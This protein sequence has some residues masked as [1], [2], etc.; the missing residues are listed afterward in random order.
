M[1]KATKERYVY[2]IFQSI[3]KG[4]DRGNRRIS[5]G[6]QKT[7]KK[8]LLDRLTA[9]TPRGGNVLDVCCGTGDISLML[10]DARRDLQVTGLDFSPAMLERAQWRNKRKKKRE[11]LYFQEGNALHL[12]YE[13]DS[14][15]AVCISFGLRNTT[16]YRKVLLEMKRVT[17][18]GGYLYCLDS[19]VPDRALVRPFYTL[20]FHHIMPVIG[21]GIRHR[22]E[23]LWLYRSTVHFLSKKELK[24]LF[25]RSGIRKVRDKDKM[26]GACVLVWGRK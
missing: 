9:W 20:Y 23:Y 10:A 21:G 25:V 17:K 4:Y 1:D 18:P 13:D 12:P 3:S 22:K 6:F 24:K 5:L 8:M 15:D 7:F 14:F 19:F 11:N 2:Q 16:D 26:F